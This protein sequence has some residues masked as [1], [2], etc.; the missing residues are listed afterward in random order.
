[1]K[2]LYQNDL[3]ETPQ[4][5]WGMERRKWL[6][7][8]L[9]GVVLS[10]VPWI[11]SC[12]N[13]DGSGDSEE[14]V[15]DGKG[16][17]SEDEMKSLYIIQNILV[18]NDGNGPSAGMVNAHDYFIWM[19]NDDKLIASEKEYFITKLQDLIN[20]SKEKFG[21][22]INTLSKKDQELFISNNI[23]SG[24]TQT[25]LSR[26]ITVIFEAMLLDPIYGGNPD[27][28]GWDWLEHIGGSPR[29]TAQTKY[30]EI[31]KTIPVYG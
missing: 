29:A 14:P 8:A 23:E 17:L 2:Q 26:M 25:F 11:V 24:W 12:D 13:N 9:A 31:Y 10:Q 20:L 16:I 5:N 7:L 22:S 4:Q 6:K 27:E 3:L 21:N 1:M 28:I 15:L 18:P 19:L 30:P